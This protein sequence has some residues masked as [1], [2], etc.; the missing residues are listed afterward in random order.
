MK[1]FWDRKFFLFV[2]GVAVPIMVQNA[3][4]NFV[5]LLDNIMVGQLGT[6]P[7]SGVSIV[8]QLLFVFNVTLFGATAGPG[9]FTSQFHG[10]KNFEG[11]RQTVR[12]KMYLCLAIFVVS[13]GIFLCF[14]QPLIRAWLHESDSVGD[15]EKTLES[16]RVYLRIM[17]W[18]LLPFAVKEV[19]ASTLRETGR[20][21]PPMLAG[22]LAVVVNLVLNYLLIFGKLGL[23]ALGVSG[24]AIATVISRFV[25][26]GVLVAWTHANSLKNQ[27][28]PGLYRSLGINRQLV[29]AVNRKGAPL[30]FNELLWASSMAILSRCYAQRGLDVV[31]GYN[32]A[33]AVI[34]LSSVVYMALGSATAI[35]LGQMLGAEKKELARSSVP[36]LACLSTLLCAAVGLLQIALSGV[37]PMLYNTTA[38]IQDLGQQFIILHGCFLPAYAISSTEYFSL[39]SGGKIGVTFL[40]DSLYSWIVAVPVAAI[41]IWGTSLPATWVYCAVLSTE[42]IKAVI[43]YFYIKRGTWL[44]NL[45]RQYS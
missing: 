45:V 11:V 1:K 34:E 33:S 20:S 28:V 36:K 10:S 25:E 8:N 7:M 4:T 22:I 14:D 41:L 35:V 9:I 40:F 26:C 5:A 37:F 30:L 32:I 12:Y 31:A 29:S 27:F 15:L 39:R 13:I 17:L 16:A 23:P 42:V 19:Y 43:G 2:L 3:I 44:H 24:A 38:H 21:V 6:E 18:G